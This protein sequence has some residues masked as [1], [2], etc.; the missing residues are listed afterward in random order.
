MFLLSQLQII[1]KCYGNEYLPCCKPGILIV[2]DLE[3]GV[4]IHQ[5]DQVIKD[6]IVDSR[7]LIELF[8]PRAQNA[9]TFSPT[10]SSY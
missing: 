6:G 9:L 5:V 8:E 4:P 3:S 7:R 10:Y 2:D 1:C